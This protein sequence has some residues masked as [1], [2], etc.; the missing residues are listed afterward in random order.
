MN[1]LYYLKL[2]MALFLS[3]SNP[4]IEY[5][6]DYFIIHTTLSNI[7]TDDMI[8]LLHSGMDFEFQIYSSLRNENDKNQIIINQFFKK[9]SYNRIEKQYIIHDINEKRFNTLQEAIIE[10]KTFYFKYPLN[11]TTK[12]KYSFFCEVSIQPDEFMESNF[13]IKTMELWSNYKPGMT[14]TFTTGEH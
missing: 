11:N 5:K 9:I 7:L 10:L 14:C 12:I 4:V 2:G 13:S 8:Q 1:I 6:P 3:F